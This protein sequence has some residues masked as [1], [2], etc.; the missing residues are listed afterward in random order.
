MKRE[1][2]KLI[3][4]IVTLVFIGLMTIYSVGAARPG[5]LGN[6][7]R[8]FL[9]IALGLFLMYRLATHFDYHWLS[10]PLVFR[11]ILGVSLLLLV[12]VLVPGIGV[13]VNGAQRWIRLPGFQFQPSELGKL[14]LIVL[15]AHKLSENQEFIKRFWRGFVPPVAIAGGFAGLV[16]LEKDLGIPVVMVSMSFLMIY[17][18][19]VRWFYVVGSLLP[20][21][22]GVAALVKVS[23]YRW[24]RLIAFLDP[25]AHRNEGGFHLIQSLAAFAHGALVGTGAGAGEQKLSYLPAAHTDFIF[26]VWGEEMGLAGTVFM[27]FL[28]VSFLLIGIRIAKC[29]PDMFGSLLAV[30][31]VSLISLQAVFNM[32]VT[33]GLMPTKGLTLPFVSYG[34]TAQIVFLILA[35]ILLNIGLQAQAPEER[36]EFAL[37]F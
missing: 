3:L 22:A 14:A 15:L 35:G 10:L 7:H 20:V 25:F 4:I 13:E 5:G 32:A 31:I 29:A 34:G 37:A 12:L 19:G 1:T 23:P 17:A 33:I 16:L 8:Q 28:F 24:Q 30:G 21:V 36:R 6:F 11:G 27:V 2:I 18:A 26:A 9:C